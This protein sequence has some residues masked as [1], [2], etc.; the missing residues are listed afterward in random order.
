MQVASDHPGNRGLPTTSVMF[1]GGRADHRDLPSIVT[2]QD[3][4]PPPGES[5]TLPVSPTSTLAYLEI[6]TRGSRAIAH[7]HDVLPPQYDS[8]RT[9]SLEARGQAERNRQKQLIRDRAAGRQDGS[10]F[11]SASSRP[12]PHYPQPPPSVE[13]S[14]W[15]GSERSLSPVHESPVRTTSANNGPSASL[16]ATPGHRVPSR[17]SSSMSTASG[18]ASF[19]GDASALPQGMSI[20]QALAQCHDPTLGWTLRFWVT[21]ADPS[22]S[23]ARSAD[24]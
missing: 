16:L 23:R 3:S 18:R 10:P 24:S 15:D 21:V 14:R 7:L 8:V 5:V 6:G 19:V 2:Q 9:P 20:Q 1:H 13:P 12:A 11:A 22:V 17:Q 4:R